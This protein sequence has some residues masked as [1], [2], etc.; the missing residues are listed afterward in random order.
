MTGSGELKR[1]AMVVVIAIGPAC[2]SAVSVAPLRPAT[3][4]QR[5]AQ[6]MLSNISKK[7]CNIYDDEK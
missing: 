1:A 4:M 2:S 6:Q 5:E 7:C 3:T